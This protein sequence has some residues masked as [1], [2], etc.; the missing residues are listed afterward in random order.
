MRERVVRISHRSFLE[1]Q[2]DEGRTILCERLA[3][4]LRTA[5][6]DEEKPYY[7]KVNYVYSR[8]DVSGKEKLERSVEEDLMKV[9]SGKSIEEIAKEATPQV[10]V[11]GIGGAG[12]NI[13]SWIKEKEVSGARIFAVHSDAQHLSVTRADRKVLLGYNVCRGL[14][15]GG[16]PEKGTRAAEESAG[17]IQKITAGSGLV[18]VTA[19][20][21]G[22]TGT[23]ATPV[24]SKIARETGA[25]TLGVVTTPFKVERARLAKAKDGLKKLVDASDAVVVIDNNRLREVAGNLPLGKAFAVANELIAMFI[26]SIAETV[27][28]PSLMNVDLAD[29]KAMMTGSG[30][31]AIGFGE[32]TGDTK[33]RDAVEK[34]LDTQLLDTG[35]VRKAKGALVLIE[36][37]D[38][39]TLEDVNRA[40]EL[41][42]ERI[43]PSAK[44]SW[45]ARVNSAIQDGMHAT[46]VLAGIDSPFLVKNLQP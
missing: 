31:C 14:G 7:L 20:L 4:A 35:D 17:E 34:A 36:G 11:L 37:G 24:I 9:S 27:A 2:K 3:D 30:I 26:K 32:G 28:I 1:D 21:G 16:F 18:F 19:G 22:G 13:V 15:C 10:S 12:C 38:D 45:G 29:L 40:G 42:I 43:A 25:L 5:E 44:V 6:R 39:M 8:P 33:V 46:V 41:V 23:G